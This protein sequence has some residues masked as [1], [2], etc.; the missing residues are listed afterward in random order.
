MAFKKGKGLTIFDGAI[1]T[2]VQKKIPDSSGS[3][4]DLLNLSH[5]KIVR[6]I[7]QNYLEAGAEFLT[8]N[9][10]S[11]SKI[12]LSKSGHE[13]KSFKINETGANLAKQAIEN[14]GESATGDRHVAGSIG[15]T[16][17]TLTPL[18]AY[19]FEQFYSSFFHQA[20]GLKK[21]GADWI[22]IETMESIREAKAALVAAKEV[23]LPVISSMSYGER[24]RTSYGV[25]PESGAVTLDHLGADVLGMNCGTGPKPYPELI[26]TYHEFTNKPLLAE[27]NAG[28]P[29]LKDGKATYELTPE[30]YLEEMRP[31]LPYLAGVGSCCGSNPGFTQTLAGV[32]SDFNLET[33]E[34]RGAKRKFISNNSSVVPISDMGDIVEIKINQGE[35]T[36]IQDKVITGKINLLNLDRVSCS[37]NELESH[38]SRQFLQ[39]RSNQPIGIATGDSEILTAF[40]QAYPGTP[41]VRITQNKTTVKQ[42]SEKYGGLLI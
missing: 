42:V 38:L 11:A 26:K 35:L 2:E 7:H 8:T 33:E 28:N 4:T 20:R 30:R 41:P 37:K 27:A 31:G 18:G 23:D 22:I 9:T 14:L 17:E 25:T 21:G 12:R 5:P 3:L 40:L 24:G 36:E 19:N 6:A 13:E 16:G 39:L 29:R 15:P 32:G 34:C 10:F 1:G